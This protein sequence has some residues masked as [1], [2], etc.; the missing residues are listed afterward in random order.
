MVL[1]Y[2]PVPEFIDLVFAKISPKRSFSIIENECFRLVFAKT[3]SIYSGTDLVVF[4][5]RKTYALICN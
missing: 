1:S 2:N 3:R 4:Y 5:Y